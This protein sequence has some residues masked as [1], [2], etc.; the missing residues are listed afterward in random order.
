MVFHKWVCLIWF[1]FCG[2]ERPWPLK[3]SM[4]RGDTSPCTLSS[5]LNCPGN[6]MSYTEMFGEWEN[7]GTSGLS[8]KY[9]LALTYL[10]CQKENKHYNIKYNCFITYKIIINYFISLSRKK[11][12]GSN[13]SFGANYSFSL[14][15]SCRTTSCISII[16]SCVTM[17]IKT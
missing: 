12:R 7:G 14:W 2:K 10:K 9:K 8:L 5:G 4:E 6:A 1:I 11:M 16:C 15:I 13:F 3:L 17:N